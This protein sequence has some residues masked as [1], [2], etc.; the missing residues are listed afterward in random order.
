VINR[1]L[2]NYKLHL[3]NLVNVLVHLR[4]VPVSNGTM[5]IT[6]HFAQTNYITIVIA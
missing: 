5:Q 3:L 1:K 6:H 2:T 4:L